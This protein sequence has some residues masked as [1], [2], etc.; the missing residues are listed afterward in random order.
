M[1]VVLLSLKEPIST[2][3][4]RS[5]PLLYYV[6]INHVYLQF[7]VRRFVVQL[8]LNI[9]EDMNFLSLHACGPTLLVLGVVFLFYF[10]LIKKFAFHDFRVVNTCLHRDSRTRLVKYFINI[11]LIFKYY[12]TYFYKF[13]YLYITL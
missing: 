12:Y 5:I 7:H 4:L 1:I 11:F 2:V 9:F 6:K 10:F 3:D 13:F 8:D